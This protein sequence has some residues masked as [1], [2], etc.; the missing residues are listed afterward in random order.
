MNDRELEPVLM[1]LFG[2]AGL[3]LLVASFV[4]PYGPADRV[5]AAIGGVL[6][7]GFAVVQAIRL[8]RRSRRHD[9][10][11]VPVEAHPDNRR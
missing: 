7:I 1:V 6:G 4:Q 11:S 9:D 5:V 2:A 10:A 8:R 3:I